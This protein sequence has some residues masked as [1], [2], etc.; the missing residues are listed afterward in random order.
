MEEFQLASQ[1]LPGSDSGVRKIR[2]KVALI[3]S[4]WESFP[5]IPTQ[6]DFIRFLSDGGK[7]VAE[8]FFPAPNY[9]Q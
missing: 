8:N 2:R 7:I 3:E 9:G 1:G 4:M 5:Q 6:L